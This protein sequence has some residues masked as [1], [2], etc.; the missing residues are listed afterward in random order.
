MTSLNQLLKVIQDIS[1]S[2]SQVNTYAQG[3]RYDI[4][5]S[6]ATLYPLVWAVPTGG[7][8]NFTGNTMDYT[9]TLIVLDKD[10][11]DGSNEIEI[12][13]DTMLILLDI[14]AK[15]SATDE[16]ADEWQITS[17]GRFEPIVDGGLDTVTG[18]SCEVVLSAFF[19]QDICSAIFN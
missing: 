15:I 4:S 3:Q 13:S 19:G 2:H 6:A 10:N 7:N 9:V 8:P 5:A 17:V 12:L 18:H 14:V 1:E 11:A 16:D